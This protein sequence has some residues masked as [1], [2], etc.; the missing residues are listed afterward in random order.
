LEVEPKEA[1]LRDE[2]K[3]EKL[4]VEVSHRQGVVRIFV[5]PLS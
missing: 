4:V 3:G 1:L 5:K 2:R